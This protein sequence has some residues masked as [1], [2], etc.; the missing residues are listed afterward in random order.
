MPALW[1]PCQVGAHIHCIHEIPSNSGPASSPWCWWAEPEWS[2]VICPWCWTM[3]I[4]KTGSSL[5]M[6][7]VLT[8]SVDFLNTMLDQVLTSLLETMPPLFWLFSVFCAQYIWCC[9]GKRGGKEE[10]GGKTRIKRKAEHR[11]RPIANRE[12]YN[13][14]ERSERAPNFEQL[15]N[16]PLSFR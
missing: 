14:S 10:K 3:F 4:F 2:W 13:A 16:P 11:E 7:K 1:R 12:Q 6:N 15:K 9:K 5:G 8:W